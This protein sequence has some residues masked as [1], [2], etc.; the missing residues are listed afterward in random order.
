MRLPQLVA[1]RGLY[2]GEF[3]EFLKKYG[4]PSKWSLAGLFAD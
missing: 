2:Q 3:K 4:Y 1:E